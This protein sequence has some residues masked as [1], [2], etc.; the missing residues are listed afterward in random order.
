MDIRP[1]HTL[2]VNNLNDKMKKADLKRALYYLFSPYGRVLEIIAMKTPKMRGQAFIIFQALTSA[3]TALRVLQGF[4][5]FD[6]PMR[7]QYARKNSTQIEVLQGVNAETQKKKEEER[8][9]RRRRKLAQ[10]Q[11]A[12]AAAAAAAGG[13]GAVVNGQAGADGEVDTE[14]PNRVLFVSNLPEETTDAMLTMLFNQFSGFKEARRAVGGIGFVEYETEA[15]ATAAKVTYHG[16]KL[17][18]THAIS[19][20]YAKH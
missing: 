20:T 3:T 15:Q 8:E 16:F 5:L 17:T 1:N 14:P 11:A 7:I 6:K 19:V 2:Y 13:A 12:A 18:R 9:K 10:R 4:Q